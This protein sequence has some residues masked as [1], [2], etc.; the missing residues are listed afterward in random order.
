L[1]SMPFP[2]LVTLLIL[3]PPVDFIEIGQSWGFSSWWLW[4]P[5]WMSHYPQFPHGRSLL[6]PLPRLRIS[7]Y[8]L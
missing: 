8:R 7:M 3:L 1:P 2:Y 4:W 6:V 5:Y